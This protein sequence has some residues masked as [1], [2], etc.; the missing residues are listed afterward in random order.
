MSGQAPVATLHDV[1][2]RYGR[3]VV[4]ESVSI[5]IYQN[6][7]L[8]L[9]GPNGGGK[10]TLLKI[11]LGLLKPDAGDVTVFGAKPVK[12]RVSLGYVPQYADFDL[13]FP[14]TVKEVVLTGR[15]GHLRFGRRYAKADLD[16]VDNAMEEMGLE[17]LSK[18]DLGSLSGGQ[19]QRV[20]VARA[21]ATE[22]RM[23]LLDEPTASVDN[24]VE[25]DFFALL[26]DLHKRIPVILVSHDLGFISAYLT[27]VACVNRRLVVNDVSDVHAHD[28]ESL[29]EGPVKMWSHKCEL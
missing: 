3:N 20:L 8:G 18:R 26:A 14:A 4:L 13:D 5:E 15:L 9:I 7:F 10:T 27:R 29:Y 25:K 22:P 23:L 19:R 16:A 12:A 2:F 1:D 6:D 11:I 17:D 28:L 24:R 21:L